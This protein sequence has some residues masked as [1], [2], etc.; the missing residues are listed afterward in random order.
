[1][2]KRK[3]FQNSSVGLS[4]TD[5]A[6]F[7]VYVPDSLKFTS[8]KAGL[9]A[10]RVPIK[11]RSEQQTYSSNNN[12][13]IRILLPNDSIY[14]TRSGY[15]TFTLNLAVVGGT[16]A[17]LHTGVFSVFN[18]LRILVASKQVEDLRDYNRIYSALWEMKQEPE[19][20]AAYGLRMGF[21]TQ[22]QRNAQTPTFDYVC[23]LWSGILNNELLPF[24]NLKNGMSLEL[25]IEDPTLCVETDSPNIPVITISNILFHVE[26][27]ELDQSYRD[28]ISSY[29]SSNGLKLGFFTWERY[30]SALTT[31]ATQNPVINQRSSSLNGILNFFVNSTQLSNMT[32]NDKFLTWLPLTLNQTSVLVNGRIFPDEPIDVSYAAAI[33]PYQIYCRWLNKWQLHGILALPPPINQTAFSTNRFVQIDDFEPYPEEDEL[34]NPFTT[35]N[36]NSNIIKKLVFGGAIAAGYQL[37]SWIEFFC[38]VCIYTDGSI[39]V[40]Q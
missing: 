12:K 1:M 31:G 26:R 23:P 35:L 37:D 2:W 38:Q 8:A 19:V 25:F 7:P 9:P 5:F 39:D 29:V 24:D 32:I 4:D 34:I 17:R 11:I 16:Y 21:G 13:L 10:R 3:E 6:N 28:F 20:N 14:D 33:E 40:I 36:A 22:A 30:V 18:R 27:L 15:L